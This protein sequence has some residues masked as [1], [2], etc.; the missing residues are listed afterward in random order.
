[1]VFLFYFLG[2]PDE[3]EHEDETALELDDNTPT[4]LD[5][6][7]NEI[8]DEEILDPWQ[9]IPHSCRR[10]VSIFIIQTCMTLI[11]HEYFYQG[12]FFFQ[13]FRSVWEKTGFTAP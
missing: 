1:M 12:K 5:E 7:D 11:R 3:I 13:Q 2:Q 9:R 4:E 10:L 8:D 6:T